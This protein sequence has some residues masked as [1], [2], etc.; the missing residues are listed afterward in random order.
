MGDFTLYTMC[1]LFPEQC[2]ASLFT[3]LTGIPPDCVSILSE[4]VVFILQAASFGKCFLTD[5]RPEGF[6]NMCQMLRV[7]NAVREHNIGIPLTYT[8]Y[9]LIRQQPH[10]INYVNV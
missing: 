4:Y 5:Y 3:L 8:Q 1:S 7:L 9:P 2:L 6:Y 10:Y